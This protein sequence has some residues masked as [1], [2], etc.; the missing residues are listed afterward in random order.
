MYVRIQAMWRGFVTRRWYHDL[1]QR[2]P[3]SDPSLRRRFFEQKF[4]VL[5]DHVVQSC[6]C[7]A[8]GAESVL[9][10]ADMALA[11]ARDVMR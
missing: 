5:T 10:E 8:S 4:S 6:E 11:G 9:A 7:S 3:P 2:I 1:R